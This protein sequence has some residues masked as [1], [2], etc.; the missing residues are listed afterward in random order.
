MNTIASIAPASTVDFARTVTREIP[1]SQ[2]TTPQ[3]T[4]VQELPLDLLD[5]VGGGSGLTLIV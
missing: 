3:S 2:A 1:Q 5:H 4:L